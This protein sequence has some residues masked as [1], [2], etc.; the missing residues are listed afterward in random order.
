MMDEPIDVMMHME[1][2]IAFS[3][4]TPSHNA[5]SA[6]IFG[7]GGDVDQETFPQFAGINFSAATTPEKSAGINFS[8][9]TSP[10]QSPG[11]NFSAATTPEKTQLPSL[12]EA[13]DLDGFDFDESLDVFSQEKREKDDSQSL[14]DGS[15]AKSKERRHKK[16]K[17]EKKHKKEREK[18]EK[19]VEKV[20]KSTVNEEIEVTCN[21]YT[22]I[23]LSFYTDCIC[24]KHF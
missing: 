2:D 3:A 9:A 8:A 13:D 15:T 16:E 19:D 6:S 12:G 23:M 5:A 24:C 21:Q 20:V 4:P 11:I 1:G 22:S 7:S 17:K 14:S 18:K 10:A